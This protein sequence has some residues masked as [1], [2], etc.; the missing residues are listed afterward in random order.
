[1]P[2]PS[3]AP[4]RVLIADDHALVR[5]GLRRL[6]VEGGFEVAGEAKDGAEA[7]RLT[8]E[9]R[10]D[11]L[12]LDVAMPE[13]TGFDALRLLAKSASQ[14][15]ILLLTAGLVR[16]EIPV[17]LKLG[18]RGVL[19]KDAE[20]DV[21]FQAIRAVHD[22]QLWVR[23][24][25]IDDLLAVPSPSTNGRATSKGDNKFG[26]TKRELELVGL[27]ASGRSNKENR[28]PVLPSGGHGQAPPQQHLRQDRCVQPARARPLRHQQPDRLTAFPPAAFGC[29][30]NGVIASGRARGADVGDRR[31][32]RRPASGS[33][34]N[35]SQ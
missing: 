21:L 33:A 10:P 25:I 12:L 2:E 7:A 1:M 29:T 5:H 13:T 3:T 4:I 24:E 34:H 14:T 20:A 6:L 28:L 18:A 35:L 32:H 31:G 9:L 26:L 23:R 19:L 15:R 27:V 8:E 17:A 30:G 22:G 11:V 16:S